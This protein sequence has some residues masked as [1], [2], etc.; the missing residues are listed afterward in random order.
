M[1]RVANLQVE[2][3]LFQTGHDFGSFRW[4]S[5]RDDWPEEM[6]LIR[7]LRATKLWQAVGTGGTDREREGGAMT[8]E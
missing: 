5:G 1:G 2:E 7:V 6:P 4:A 8:V 3:S